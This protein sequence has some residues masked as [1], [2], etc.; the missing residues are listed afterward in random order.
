MVESFRTGQHDF[1]AFMV[2]YVASDR[3]AR[4][5]LRK[6]SDH[7]DED[8][9]QSDSQRHGG[10]CGILAAARMH[11]SSATRARR[12]PPPARYAI[13]FAGQALGCDNYAKDQSRINGQSVT[14]GGHYIADTNYGRGFALTT[15]LLPLQGMENDFT[16]VSNL[17]IPFNASSTDGNAVP[18]GGRLPRLPRWRLQPAAVWDAIHV[19]RNTYLQR[20]HLRPSHRRSSTRGKRYPQVA[21]GALA[22]WLLRQRV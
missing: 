19:S 2:E 14:E 3:F 5:A 20:H 12:K 10:R 4:D 13:L 1:K 15:P 22:T 7:G 16:M 11:A 8:Q 21:R 6:G 18:A 9:S 17:A